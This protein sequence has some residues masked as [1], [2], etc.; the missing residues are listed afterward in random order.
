MTIICYSPQEAPLG[1]W[2]AEALRTVAADHEVVQCNSGEALCEM[3]KEFRQGEA[4]F[5]LVAPDSETLD[6]LVGFRERLRRRDTFLVLPDSDPNT[7]S[8]G[9][10]LYPRFVTHVGGDVRQVPLVVAKKLGCTPVPEMLPEL[11]VRSNER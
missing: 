5:V 1:D 8:L 11:L 9:R 7:L 6:T 10:T 2:L 4:V 3:D